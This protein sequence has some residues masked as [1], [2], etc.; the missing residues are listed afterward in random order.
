MINPDHAFKSLDLLYPPFRDI[1]ALSLEQCHAQG[2]M[3]YAFE[4]YRY[5]MRQSWLYG[6]GRSR[7]G[8]IITNAKAGQSWHQYA[9]AVDVAFD[10]RDDPGIQWD[11]NGDWQK[12]GAIFKSHGAE[13][14]GDSITFPEKPHFQL[15]LGLTIEDA[16]YIASKEGIIGVWI[17]LES[18]RK[19]NGKT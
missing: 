4:T 1:V 3:I 8:K 6:Q 9:L 15:T 10:G 11:W 13:W 17:E 5:P 19:A 12:V 14:L 18:R 16:Q 2:L 7:S